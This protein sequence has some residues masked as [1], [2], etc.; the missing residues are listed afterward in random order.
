M[1]VT[2]SYE[3]LLISTALELKMVNY[4]SDTTL[5]SSLGLKKYS[6]EFIINN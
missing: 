6:D 2:S 1:L 5:I 3:S 4:L